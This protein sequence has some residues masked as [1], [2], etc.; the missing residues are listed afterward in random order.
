MNLIDVLFHIEPKYTDKY[1]HV[2]LFSDILDACKLYG[3]DNHHLI[4][5][6][7]KELERQR[8][9]DIIYLDN[10]LDIGL[11]IGVQLFQKS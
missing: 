10:D 6:K 7:L 9:L 8:Q 11:I 1:G 5:A 4:E 3:Q 2:I